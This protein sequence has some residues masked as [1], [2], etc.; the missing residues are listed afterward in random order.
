MIIMLLLFYMIPITPNK[1]N[2]TQI[3]KFIPVHSKKNQTEV[4]ILILPTGGT[5]LF[6]TAIASIFTDK[7]T[8]CL[9]L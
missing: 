8:K 1:N 2:N 6:R 5:H 7:E 4:Y 3:I 9:K